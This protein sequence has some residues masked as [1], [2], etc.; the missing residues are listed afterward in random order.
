MENPNK[1]DP[2]KDKPVQQVPVIESSQLFEESNEIMIRH[3]GAVYRLRITR[4]GKL[5][6]NK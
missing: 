1:F 5:I 4:N 3:K 6:M 2:K